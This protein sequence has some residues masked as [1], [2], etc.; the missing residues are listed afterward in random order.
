MSESSFLSRKYQDLPGSK[1]V[2]RAVKKSLEAGASGAK[3]KEERI[4]RYIERLE[5]L[6][7]ATNERG[8]RRGLELLKSR[9]LSVNVTKFDEIP[10]SYWKAQEGILR[11]RGQAGDLAR[12]TDDQKQEA[13]RDHA[14]AVLQ[15]QHASLEQWVDYFATDDSK[16]PP[17]LK[18]WIL[19]E[20]V[21]LKEYDKDKKAFL[22]RSRGTVAQFPDLNHEALGYIV[23]ALQKKLSGVG[24]EFEHDIQPHEREAFNKALNKESFADLYSWANELMHPIPEELLPTTQ[25]E[26]VKYNKGSNHIPLVESV[27]GWGTGWCTAGEQTAKTQLATGDFWL[28]KTLDE[29]GNPTIPRLAIRMEGDHIAEVRG[30]ARK[31]NVD[32]YMGGVLSQKLQ[33]IPGGEVYL[34]RTQDMEQM[35]KLERKTKNREPF[36]KEDLVFLYELR[37]PIEGFGYVK[38]PRIIELRKDRNPDEDMLVVFEC[39]ENQ[40]ARSVGQINESTKAY[41]G[42]LEPSNFDRL[43]EGVE[44]VYT[45]FP[46]GRIRRQSIEIG[47]KDERELEALL[48]RSGH[49]IYT[50]AKSMMAN[51]D[52]KRSLR[53]PDPKQP[54]WKKWKLKSPEEVKLI[55]LRVEDLGFPGGATTD[56]IFAKA[57]ELG[58]ELCPPE[59][60]PQFRLQ[61]VNQP[62]NE[63]VYVGMKQISVSDGYPRVFRVARGDGGSWLSSD[64]GKPGS[65]WYAGS[66]FVFRLRKPARQSEAPA[67]NP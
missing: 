34:K 39:D 43:P 53:E 10:E 20:V 29:D 62:M 22:P 44:H 47:G 13:R 30:I 17:A 64:W 54:D 19:R 18:Y 45:K 61:Y 66:E 2:E 51:E 7:Q 37:A 56:Q 27:R 55:R 14:K 49:K 40:I 63:Y 24:I 4:D 36:T 23:D 58:L 48:E 41:V 15:D 28:Y 67:G 46:E 21:K 26:W 38:D 50:Y 32:A 31:Q 25:G 12:F 57:Q 59:V 35:K 52:F 9:F 16:I 60:G 1:G 8:D 5:H 65:K 6:T 42:K 11:E 3:T 33:E